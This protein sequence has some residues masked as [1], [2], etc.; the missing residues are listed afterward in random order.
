[1]CRY[2]VAAA[3]I[4]FT[5]ATSPVQG[6]DE[7]DYSA[8]YLVVE[9]GELVTKYPAR[10]HEAGDTAPGATQDAG[11]ALD[12][13]SQTRKTGTI[14]AIVLVVVVAFLAHARRRS[15]RDNATDAK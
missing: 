8:P 10:E 12:E 15:K 2:F 1:M 11:P 4:A 7:V 3:L 9:N 6:G 13:V 14:V 5:A